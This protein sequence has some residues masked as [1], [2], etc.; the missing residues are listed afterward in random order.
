MKL[1]K[2]YRFRTKDPIIDKLRTAFQDAKR[3]EPKLTFQAISED[4]GLSVQTPGNWFNGD[5]RRPQFATCM[6]FARAIGCDLV[7][8]RADN[9]RSFDQPRVRSVRVVAH[10]GQRRKTG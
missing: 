4:S 1:Y 6:A 10:H 5:T 2:S 7:I 3:R 8:V 9:V